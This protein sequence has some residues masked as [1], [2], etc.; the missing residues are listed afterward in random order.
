MCFGEDGVTSHHFRARYANRQLST[1]V[2]L[3]VARLVD[4]EAFLVDGD[5]SDDGESTD[6]HLV[7][8]VR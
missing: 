4:H 3:L 1:A 7:A 8:V 5:W 2:A 6:R